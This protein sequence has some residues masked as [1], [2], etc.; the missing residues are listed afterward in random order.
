VLLR[1]FLVKTEKGAGFTLRSDDG[2]SWVV[3]K[4]AGE[5]EVKGPPVEYGDEERDHVTYLKAWHRN[6]DANARERLEKAN[7]DKGV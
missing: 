5:E 3:F 2:S 7:G 6:L 1:N 4:Q